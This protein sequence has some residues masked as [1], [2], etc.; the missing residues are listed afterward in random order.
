MHWVLILASQIGHAIVVAHSIYSHATLVAHG[1]YGHAT[2]VAHG[3]YGHATLS[4][5]VAEGTGHVIV[6]A[7]RARRPY[8]LRIKQRASAV[9]FVVVHNAEGN[10]HAF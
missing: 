10:C 6:V 4:H 3:I 5:Y 9:R 7:Q 1:I 8:D 2:L